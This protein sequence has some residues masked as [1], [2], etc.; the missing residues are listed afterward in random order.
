MENFGSE[1]EREK[2]VV[3]EAIEEL[4]KASAPVRILL[5]FRRTGLKTGEKG[6][7]RG[8][9]PVAA[10]PDVQLFLGLERMLG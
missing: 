1:K 2:H 4:E 7:N 5:S 9:N 8:D 3:S 6:F 10:H